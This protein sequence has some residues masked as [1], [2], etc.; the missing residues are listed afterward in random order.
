[1]GVG[2]C[3]VS[4]GYDYMNIHT[5]LQQIFLESFMNYNYRNDID[6][7]DTL[8]N[9]HMSSEIG[10]LNRHT[11]PEDNKASNLNGINMS[12]DQGDLNGDY[13]YMYISTTG[14]ES[15]NHNSIHYTN[16]RDEIYTNIYLMEN[17]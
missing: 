15:N 8:Q 4:S 12:F 14:Y 5:D 6:I 3:D 1:M 11:L 13:C 7:N 17:N 10:S 2:N 9:G 16:K